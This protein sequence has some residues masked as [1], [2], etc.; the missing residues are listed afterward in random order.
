M[1]VLGFSYADNP[2]GEG[3]VVPPARVV[4]YFPG[5]PAPEAPGYFRAPL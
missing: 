5:Y 3:S 2:D 4:C 1:R